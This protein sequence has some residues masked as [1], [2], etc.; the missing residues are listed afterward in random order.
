LLQLYK[1]GV[2]VIISLAGETGSVDLVFVLDT[3]G[4]I[5]NDDF[6]FVREFVANVSM[7]LSIS[8][9]R[10]QVAV[11]LYSSNAQ[12]HFNLTMHRNIT[13]LND[14][15]ESIPYL[16][17]GTNTAGALN[18]LQLSYFDGSLGIRDGYAHYAVVFT[19]G[20]SN[21]QNATIDAANSLHS[22][23]DF[24]VYSVGISGAQN[25]ELIAIATESSN[26]FSASSFAAF[27][28][29][30]N[31]I[32]QDIKRTSTV[33]FCKLQY[34]I[35]SQYNVRVNIQ[36]CEC[37]HVTYL[38]TRYIRVPFPHIFYIIAIP[39]KCTQYCTY[40]V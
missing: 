36:Y 40:V 38:L 37:M 8:S 1:H 11:I 15:I 19:D 17:G 21:N 20:E 31:S 28:Q 30:S 24:Q 14:G 33:C 32:I 39:I 12:I 27:Q 29:F 2:I 4:S 3:S 35:S 5:G 7:A 18:L 10:S 23:T 22:N 34:K 26:V 6:Q 25:I 9:T 16:G 13:A